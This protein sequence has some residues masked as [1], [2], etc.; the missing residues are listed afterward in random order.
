MAKIAKYEVHQINFGREEVNKINA[1]ELEEEYKLYRDTVCFPKVE[2]ILSARRLYKKA[3]IVEAQSLD[4]V[5]QIGNIGPEERIT[6]LG[7]FHSVSVGDII[8]DPENKAWLVASF[9]FEP[10]EE[11]NV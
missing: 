5:F 9:G 4:D 7:P 6:R 10:V 2:A 3:G 11:W 1:G 8:V